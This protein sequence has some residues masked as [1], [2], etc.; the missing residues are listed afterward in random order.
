MLTDDTVVE[1]RELH[2][3]AAL[4]ASVTALG[5]WGVYRLARSLAWSDGEDDEPPQRRGPWGL[6]VLYLNNCMNID[7][8]VF[9]YLS[10]FPLLSVVGAW[11]RV[12]CTAHIFT[13]KSAPQIYEGQPLN[14]G[15][16]G[17]SPSTRR[18]MRVYMT[19][20]ISLA[21]WPICPP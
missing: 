2:T 21:S 17:T 16:N 7:N 4:D 20:L 10:R 18:P 13:S 14:R 19:Q 3:L 12:C 5:S 6:R 11:S 1:L 9:S 15:L 8:K